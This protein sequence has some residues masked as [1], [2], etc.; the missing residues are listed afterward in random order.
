MCDAIIP[1]SAFV[2]TIFFSSDSECK[3]S[4][5]SLSLEFK[6]LLNGGI[7]AIAN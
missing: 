2:R 7:E 4:K 1:T 5:S 6:N 3:P